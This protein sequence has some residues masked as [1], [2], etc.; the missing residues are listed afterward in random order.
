MNKH[1]Y[2]SFVINFSN[3]LDLYGGTVV[4]FVGKE[5]CSRNFLLRPLR[6][7]QC[8]SKTMAGVFWPSELTLCAKSICVTGSDQESAKKEGLLNSRGRARI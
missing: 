8:V 7:P 6:G 4:C 1:V 2:C 5:S 3:P